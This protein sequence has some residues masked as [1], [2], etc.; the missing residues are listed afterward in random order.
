MKCEDPIIKLG[1]L[2]QVLPLFNSLM[3]LRRKFTV[4]GNHAYKEIDLIHSIV[5]SR[6]M[7]FNPKAKAKKKAFGL[8]PKGYCKQNTHKF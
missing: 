1:S 3:I 4:A 7:G 6:F 2:S 5:F 8:L